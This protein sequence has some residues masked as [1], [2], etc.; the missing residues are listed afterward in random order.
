MFGLTTDLRR[1]PAMAASRRAAAPVAALL[2]VLLAASCVADGPDGTKPAAMKDPVSPGAS[3]TGNYLAG[4]HA[5]ARGDMSAA[6]DFIGAALKQSPDTP[7][8]L[9]RTFVLT[10]M[11][12]RMEA[13]TVLARRVV[14]VNDK[15]PIAELMVV[16][17]DIRAGR[18]ADAEKRLAG[19]SNNGFNVV[20][21]P[22]PLARAL[23]GLGRPKTPLAALKPLA[24]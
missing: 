15:A 20:M 11:N 10:A 13:A 7:N 14:A 9:R 2:T 24:A 16:V 21:R 5:Q 4:R 18:F 6:A 12:G 17:D 19:L 23:V 1:L 22:L 3:L 8:L